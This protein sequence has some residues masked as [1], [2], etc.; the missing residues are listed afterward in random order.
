MSKIAIDISPLIDGNKLRG[1]GYYTKHLVAALQIEIKTNP[2]YKDY[3][4]KLITN[5]LEI[6]SDYDLVHYPYFTPFKL[7]LPFIKKK[8]TIISIHDVIERQFK[9]HYPVGI[10]GEIK[11]QIQKFLARQSDYIITVSHYSKYIIADQFQYQADHIY[12]TPEAA[13]RNYHQKYSPEYLN[14]IKQKIPKIKKK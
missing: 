7:T 14:K 5:K 1:V 4:I 8:P 10:K 6:G 9:K 13:D 11:W 2:D 3:E 12:V